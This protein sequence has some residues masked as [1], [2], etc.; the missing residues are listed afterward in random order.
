MHKVAHKFPEWFIE[1]LE[2]IQI[3]E[4]NSTQT[5]IQRA[6]D[7]A[8]D[9]FEGT[10]NGEIL[11]FYEFDSKVYIWA[12]KLRNWNVWVLFIGVL[13][14]VVLVN[15]SNYASAGFIC[16]CLYCFVLEYASFRRIHRVKAILVC[17]VII[18]AGFGNLQLVN[19]IIV[20]L[21][22]FIEEEFGLKEL[23]IIMFRTIFMAWEYLVHLLVVI[24]FF[25]IVGYKLW[26]KMYSGWE[27][28]ANFDSLGNSFLSLFALMSTQTYPDAVYPAYQ[29]SPILSM[30]FFITFVIVCAIFA[31]SGILAVVVQNYRILMIEQAFNEEKRRVKNLIKSFIMISFTQNKTIDDL[32]HESKIDRYFFERLCKT[33]FETVNVTHIRLMFGIKIQINAFNFI[34]F[35]EFVYKQ[36]KKEKKLVES[37]ES[38]DSWLRRKEFILFKCLVFMSMSVSAVFLQTILLGQIVLYLL[39]TAMIL[40]IYYRYK[41]VVNDF[42]NLFDSVIMLLSTFLSIFGLAMSSIALQRISIILVLL[43]LISEIDS[44]FFAQRS[45]IDIFKIFSLVI[46]RFFTILAL[47]LYIFSAL[48]VLFFKEFEYLP[49][50]YYF[51][52]YPFSGLYQAML[53]LFSILTNSNWFCMFFILFNV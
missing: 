24:L 15:I 42:R 40:Q 16:A 25:S 7:Y 5:C 28:T 9:A 8:N 41:E 51:L 52:K 19:L 35:C 18:M 13:L 34:E 44:L 53:S 37:S 14:N 45:G 10:N 38:I 33:W 22:C 49:D 2:E 32:S 36:E 4:S 11:A 12:K 26:N 39:D 47:S 31:R 20:C 17:A 27:Y 3:P 6:V 48:G 1:C 46:L 30:V 21:Y 23:W 50:D 29:N 43:R